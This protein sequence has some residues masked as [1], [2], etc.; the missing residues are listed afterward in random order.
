MKKF[1]TLLSLLALLVS[2]FAFVVPGR[3]AV[4]GPIILMGIDAEDGGPGGHG[5][6]TN[7]QAVV[8]SMFPNI[9]NGGSGILVI[10]G[11]KSATDAVTRFWNAIAAGTGKSVTYVNGSAIAG[12]SFN[13]FALLAV[14]S[15]YQNTPSGG[16]TSAENAALAGRQADVAAF[17]NN[18][19]GLLG[20]SATGFRFQSP[21]SYAYLAGLGSFTFSF[22]PQY[23]NIT[24]T[25]EGAAIGITDALDVCCW[26]DQ[27]ETFPSFLRVL[28]T[29]AA[30]GKAAAIGGGNV[31][32]SDI[33]LAPIT[34]TKDVGTS[35][36]VTATVK[37]NNVATSGKTVT[38]TVISGPH[39]GV[40][41]TDVT[42]SNGEATFSYTGTSA[43]LDTIEASFVDSASN[44]QT[45]NRVT[46]DWIQSNTPPVVSAG[47]PYQGDEG[48]PVAL[49]GDVSDAD[50]DPL[51]IA[52]SYGVLSGV[53]AGATCTFADATAVDTTITCTDDGEYYV[54]LTADDGV[55]PPVSDSII[56]LI[57]DN[58]D[59]VLG[60]IT[61]STTDPVAVNNSI[62]ISASYSD[63]GSNDTHD[64]SIEWGDGSTS[65]GTAS[66]GTASGSHTYTAAGVYTVR[67]TVI[68]DDGG[69]DSEIYQYVVVYD[70]SA[71]F[72]TG[73]GWIDSPAGAYTADPSLTGKANFGFVSK[74]KKGATVP[75]GQTQFQ[76]HA[77]NLNF[78]ST[79]YQWL[80]V[81]GPKAQYKGSGTI[82]GSG[83][84]G[85]ILTA[86]DGQVTGGGGVDRFRIKIWDKA[87]GAVVYDNQMGAGD[88]AAA[89]N[90]IEG[91][92]IVVHSKK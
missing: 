9:S 41:G 26:H 48:S 47:G 62:S 31:V 33:Q 72:V 57:I 16:L 80:V 38:F 83:D 10:G 86:N 53:D 1:I 6:N 13:G 76:F 78:H 8:N 67:L 7:Y 20:F 25:P 42:D 32:I 91:G 34:G 75:D 87:T 58:V 12:Q 22:P 81:S 61:P 56:V 29:N 5:P 55:N 17:I 59:P 43:G 35:H 18:G 92:S 50:N 27:Y 37:E 28:A 66:A 51:T 79:S 36:T 60:A 30:T 11:G 71:G 84:Y 73:G 54:T 88:D 21:S 49:D 63:A 90:A 64:A 24:P 39:A 2:S 70:P 14:V 46:V 15:D 3:A 74:Y 19:G 85:F 40:T 4:G 23:R 52:W 89:T 65:V 69:S 45:S 77:G 68:D 82:N 44:V